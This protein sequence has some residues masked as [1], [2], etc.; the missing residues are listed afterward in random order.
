MRIGILSDTHDQVQRTRYAVAM[1]VASG[2]KALIHCG[3]LT[4]AD[5]VD[6]CS[7]LPCYFVFGNCDYDCESL[8]QA[9]HRVGGTCLDRGGLISLGKRRLAVSHGDS[10]QELRRLAALEPDYLF[11]GHT[12]VACDVQKGSTRWINP[13]ALHRASQW[14]VAVLDIASNH[15]SLLPIINAKMQR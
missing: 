10:D 6:E 8:R 11:S 2:A 5:V 14:S 4:T 12:H 15:V 1:L 13:G 7:A 9:I 3:D